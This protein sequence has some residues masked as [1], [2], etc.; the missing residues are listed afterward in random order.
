MLPSDFKKQHNPKNLNVAK[1]SNSLI[2]SFVKKNNLGALKLL[3]YISKSGLDYDKSKELQTFSINTKALLDYCNMDI[4][5]LKRN[6]IQMQETVITFIDYDNEGV[7]R[8][9]ENINV[10]PY[11]KIDYKGFI[12]IK[13]FTKI[14]NL[15]ADVKNKF[16]IVDI[17]NLMRLKSKHSV[18]MIQLLEMIEGFSKDIAKRKKYTLFECNNLFGTNY[19]RF[20]DFE[21]KILIPVKQELDDLSSL[22]FIYTLNYSKTNKTAGR[23]FI[24]SVTIDLISNRVRQLKLF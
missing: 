16:T 23:P 10:I 5:T 11:S 21:R 19:K 3:F 6:I 1:I 4:K 8:F 14:L 15:I 7:A 22:S 17:E 13:M 24:D 9:E 20:K 12:N 18:K 2:E